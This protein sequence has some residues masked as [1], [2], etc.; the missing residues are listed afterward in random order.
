M[1]LQNDLLLRAAWGQPTE[2]PPVWL[3][4]QAG[5]ILP[6]YRAVRDSLK[7]F[8][9][10]VETPALAAEVTIQPV[11]ILGVDAAILFSDILVIPQAM[12]LPYEMVEKRGPYFPATIRTKD[13]IERLVSGDDAA[14]QLEFVYEALR[15]TKLELAGRV[16]LIGFAGAPWTLFAYMVEGSGSKTFS[17]AKALLFGQPVLAHQLL[18][19][20]TDAVIAYLK[21]KVAAG[22]DLIQ[23]FD[24][25]AGILGPD[26]Y[27]TFSAPYIARICKALD[28]VPV[29][30]FAKGA[31]YALED[32]SHMECQVIG[33]DWTMAPRQSRRIVGPGKTLQGNLDPCILLTDPDLIAHKTQEMLDAFGP[34][35]I[36][37]LGHGVYPETPVENVRRFVETI[38]AYRYRN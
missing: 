18:E 17:K 23:L 13:D 38:K 7:D 31:W 19:K 1:K 30:V 37:N 32:F 22:A 20:I 11:D 25:W 8:R 2:R 16:P 21:N 14:A 28:T 29:T 27:A 9:E 3:M 4:R 12:G 33:L 36:A 24:S 5:R 34:G 10:L 15:I 6:E 26:A 35:H